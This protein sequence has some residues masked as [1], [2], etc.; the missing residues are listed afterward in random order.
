M[1]STGGEAVTC[2]L[3]HG[4]ERGRSGRGFPVSVCA[5]AGVTAQ[6][7]QGFQGLNSAEGKGDGTGMVTGTPWRPH[8]HGLVEPSPPTIGAG[9]SEVETS[10]NAGAG[11]CLSVRSALG[12][13][14]VSLGQI[15]KPDTSGVRE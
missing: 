1:L 6:R 8:P 7:G 2:V 13:T 14:T 15:Q 3:G 12:I 4:G 5:P 11:R 9:K 10:G